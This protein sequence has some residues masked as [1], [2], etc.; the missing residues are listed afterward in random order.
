MSR[1]TS[2][3]DRVTVSAP[4]P[5]DWDQMIGTDRVRFCGQCNLNVYNLSAL[6]RDEAEALIATNEGRLCVR[7]YSRTDGSILTKNC[8]VG[9]QVIQRRVSRVAQAAGAAI[10]SFLAGLGLYG[11]SPTP[12][13]EPRLTMGKIAM[14]PQRD[15][16]MVE[17]I[18]E[19]VHELLGK[20]R[21]DPRPDSSSQITAKVRRGVI[22]IKRE[23]EPPNKVVGYRQDDR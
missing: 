16:P 12:Y 14:S 15:H 13:L 22:K 20:F 4:C 17:P 8:P 5:A 23:R 6:S 19:N 7:F 3:L 21:T 11:L 2:N 9:L 18:K 10:V 1:F